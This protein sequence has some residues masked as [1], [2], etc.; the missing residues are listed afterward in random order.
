MSQLLGGSSMELVRIFSFYILQLVLC[1]K[2]YQ[3]DSHGTPGDAL[4]ETK[5]LQNHQ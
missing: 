3:D 2:S 4:K 5:W 1:G